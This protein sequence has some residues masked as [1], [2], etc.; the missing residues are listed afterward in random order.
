M[1]KYTF[2]AASAKIL[3]K[4]TQKKMICDI[5]GYKSTNIYDLYEFGF[6]I[7][8]I[9]KKPLLDCMDSKIEVKHVI[10]NF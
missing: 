7:D 6:I 9:T 4:R 5:N 8:L 1:G 2:I 3:I 10:L